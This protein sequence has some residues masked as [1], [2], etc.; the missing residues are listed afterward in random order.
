MKP[1]TSNKNK[2]VPP[3][4]MLAQSEKNPATTSQSNGDEVERGEDRDI[5]HDRRSS[6][7]NTR[8][9][10]QR[11]VPND[12][13]DYDLDSQ[14]DASDD[15][16]EPVNQ[17]TNE[18]HTLLCESENPSVTDEEWREAIKK[19]IKAITKLQLKLARMIS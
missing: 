18:D 2:K 9:P 13:K 5:D 11:I 17:I 3:P 7:G 8:S 14:S 16:Q 12:L 10:T 6:Q 15:F 19:Q 1:S 4:T